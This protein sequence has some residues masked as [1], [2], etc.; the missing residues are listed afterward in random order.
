VH[1]LWRHPDGG[2]VNHNDLEFWVD[3]AKRLDAGGVD[4]IFFA[5]IIGLYGDYQGGY[6]L[7][8]RLGM[9]FPCN[10]PV[11]VGRL[12]HCHQ[13]PGERLA[14]LWSSEPARTR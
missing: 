9:Q 2:Q 7:H 11:V 12:E 5:D 1:G 10:D 4:A 6:D 13:R 8:A 14:E 3:L